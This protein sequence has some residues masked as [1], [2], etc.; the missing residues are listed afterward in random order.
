[1]SKKKSYM[2]G[3]NIILRLEAQS[4]EKAGAFAIVLECINFKLAKK[5]TN[6]LKIPTIGI[7]S[8]Y[9]CDGQILVSND[10]LGLTT[11]AVPSF[12][13]S[14]SNLSENVIQSFQEYKNAVIERKYPNE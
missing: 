6:S 5:I 2:D 9:F 10:L 11:K 4:I 8:S 1:M 14:F 12:V 13:H 7:G 3:K